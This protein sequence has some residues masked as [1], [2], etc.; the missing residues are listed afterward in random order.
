MRKKEYKCWPGS[1]GHGACSWQEMAESSS[2]SIAGK[3][4]SSSTLFTG[5]SLPPILLSVHVTAQ[6]L[7]LR[8]PEPSLTISISRDLLCISDRCLQR[9]YSRVFSIYFMIH[10]AEFL[11][12]TAFETSG[13]NA[14]SN[15]EKAGR[16]LKYMLLREQIPGDSEGQGSLA[17][18]STWDH[19]ESD[20]T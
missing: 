19:K 3:R 12:V 5:S 20:R 1:G 13:K 18:C 16:N 9:W 7:H 8:R 10:R 11:K 14:L 6:S 15:H 4:P 2:P 17:H